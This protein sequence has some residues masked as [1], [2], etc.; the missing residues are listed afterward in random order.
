MPKIAVGL[1][2]IILSQTVRAQND[3]R[4]EVRSPGDS[5][6]SVAGEF[7]AEVSGLPLLRERKLLPGY[8]EYRFEVICDL[9][10]PHYL[11]RLRIDSRGKVSG[12]A[13][14]LWFGL[15]S[16]E[17]SDTTERVRVMKMRPNNCATPLKKSALGDDDYTWCRARVVKNLNWATLLRRLDSLR[18]LELPSAAGYSPDPP[19][20]GVDTVK[21]ADR[22]INWAHRDCNDIGGQS[23]E[24]SALGGAEFRSAHVW[25][26]ESKAPGNP[27][28]TRAAQ[29][30]R[31]LYDAI[32]RYEDP[33]DKRGRAKQ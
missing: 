32:V 21:R 18:V 11:I 12:D 8:R 19:N 10:L 22:T 17:Q 23:M 30:Y 20:L 3:W 7:T 5:V 6:S 13:H 15:D 27:E 28:H 29:A 26:L 24:I 31:I 9:C 25:C 16:S 14:M 1:A 2:L 33:R 4:Y